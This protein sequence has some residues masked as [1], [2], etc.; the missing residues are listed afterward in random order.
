MLATFDQKLPIAIERAE[1]LLLDRLQTTGHVV[2]PVSPR[3]AARVRERYRVA[4][5]KDDMFDAFVPAARA[6]PL[7]AATGAIAGAR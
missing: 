3:I 6:H 5:V 1:G 2:F 7:A 4:S